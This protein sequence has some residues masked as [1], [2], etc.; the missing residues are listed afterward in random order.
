MGAPEP[1]QRRGTKAELT[2][3]GLRYRLSKHFNHFLTEGC[4]IRHF[5]QENC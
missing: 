1:Q 5:K 4:I 3:R 2:E